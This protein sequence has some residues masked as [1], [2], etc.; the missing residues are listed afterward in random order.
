MYKLS[1]GLEV[2]NI[3]EELLYLHSLSFGAYP[4][5]LPTSRDFLEWYIERPGLGLENIL[6]FLYEDKVVSSLFLTLS[7]IYLEGELT[8]VGIIDTVMTHPDYRRRGLASALLKEAEKIMAEKEC[9]MGYLYTVPESPQFYLYQRLGYVDFKRI[10]HLQ[11]EKG[12]KPFYDREGKE[13]PHQRVREFLNQNLSSYNGFVYF[14]EEQWMWR[15]AKRPVCL[16]TKLISLQDENNHLLATLTITEGEITT[17]KDSEPIIYL[18]DWYGINQEAKEKVLVKSLRL[19][20]EERKIDC[21]SSPDNR[22]E[23]KILLRYNFRPVIPESAMLH[24][25]DEDIQQKITT[26]DSKRPWYPLIESIVGV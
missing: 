16:P 20:G 23:W 19:V 1:R 11:R 13:S 15:K 21:L 26:I 14:S 5:V 25:L 18:S 10:F 2:K 4:G 7:H 8:P 12:E 24:P 6:L 9:R 22:E 3:V 17:D